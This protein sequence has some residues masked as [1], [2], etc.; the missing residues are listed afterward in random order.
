MKP[1]LD[2]Y[3]KFL[4]RLVATR[5]YGEEFRITVIPHLIIDMED[6]HCQAKAKIRQAMDYSVDYVLDNLRPVTLWEACGE[7]A[8]DFPKRSYPQIPIHEYEIN[9][10]RK[11]RIPRDIPL[12]RTPVFF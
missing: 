3:F 6:S 4:G 5:R 1:N 7:I 8:P 9:M 2:K 10:H 11:Y 12:G